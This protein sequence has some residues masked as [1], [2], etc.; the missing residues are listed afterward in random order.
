VFNNLSTYTTG[1]ELVAGG[2]ITYPPP[3]ITVEG[4]TSLTLTT[5]VAN[6]SQQVESLAI[7]FTLCV[8]MAEI[9]CKL[10]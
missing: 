5:M 6:A 2:N 7:T 9:K 8:N 4:N 1:N 3:N 10:K